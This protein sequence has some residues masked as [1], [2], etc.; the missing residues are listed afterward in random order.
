MAE[1]VLFN[2]GNP[3][4]RGAALGH[5]EQRVIAEA[6]VALR[7]REDPPLPLGRRD[8]RSAFHGSR[9]GG[10]V[11]QDAAISCRT[12]RGRNRRQR[13]QQLGIVCGIVRTRAGEP[14]GMDA[15]RAVERIHFEARVVG[16][17]RAPRRRGGMS[18]LDEGILEE[19]RAGFLDRGHAE[20]PL[21]DHV[22]RQVR[23][24][25]AKFRKFARVAGRDD[26]AP[27]RRARSAGRHAGGRCPGRRGRAIGR[28]RGAG[29][30]GPR[31]YPEPRRRRRHCS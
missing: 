27:R 28:V 9:H 31:R 3:G 22:E 24:Q 25:A 29:T 19:A 16:E 26:E 15:R 6:A 14:R 7:G 1:A 4:G 20:F 2:A 10:E 23:E 12:A 17:R 11:Y 5:P 30:H 13:P 21:A 18:C 8:D